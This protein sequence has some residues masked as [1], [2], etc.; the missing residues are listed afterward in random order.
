MKVK[1]DLEG[2]TQAANAVNDGKV[3]I[4]PTDTVYGIG[5]DPFNKKAVEE[6]FRIKQRDVTKSLPVLGYSKNEL[7][8][9]VELNELHEKI[10]AQFWPGPLTIIGKIKDDKLKDSLN[11]SEKIAVRVPN[12]QCVL[13]I[14]KKCKLLV[15][16]SA[17]ISGQKSFV[18]P[19]EYFEQFKDIPIFVD[20]GKI[21]SSGESTI[22]ELVGNEVKVIR[23]GKITKEEILQTL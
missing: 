17:N 19:E 14:L 21:I 9:I 4:F 23:E 2:I 5:C 1:C 6:I 16:T 22:I 11:L 10:I 15:G 3:I 13:E 18:E 20:G 8:S 7:E 12:N